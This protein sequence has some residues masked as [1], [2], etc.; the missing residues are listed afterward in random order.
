MTLIL[1]FILILAVAATASMY[2]AA[3]GHHRPLARIEDIERNTSPLDLKCFGRIT[4]AKDQHFLKASLPPMVYRRI[5]R[6]RTRIAIQYVRLAARNAAVLVSFAEIQS[7]SDSLDIQTKARALAEESFRL[8]MICL[9]AIVMLSISLVFPDHDISI[10]D[11]IS[12]YEHMS[13]SLGLLSM[14][15]DPLLASRSRTWL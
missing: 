10:S 9:L 13:D 12:K 1:F 4:D 6:E 7:A 5:Q 11:V 3:R 14:L 15:T 8:R 2:F